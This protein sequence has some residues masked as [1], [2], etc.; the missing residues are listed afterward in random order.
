[1]A[2]T[3]IVLHHTADRSEGDQYQKVYDYHNAGAPDENGKLK[4]PKGYGIQYVYFIEQSGK[5]IK[6]R[7]EEELTWHAG[8]VN[9]SSIAVCLAGDFRVQE[10]TSTQLE[11][12]FGVINDLKRRH[13][14]K[15]IY[16]HYE[17]RPTK[18]PAIDLVNLYEREMAV[19]NMKPMSYAAAE[20]RR[21]KRAINRS[22]G[23][24]RESLKRR[25][26]RIFGRLEQKDHT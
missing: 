15:H 10:P 2:K 19:R 21:T 8:R 25:L 4:W 1:M 5:K 26:D 24:L 9:E 22:T 3:I 13:P 6:G 14:I 23:T 7:R 17:V 11:S 12:M 20:I 18:C 16:N